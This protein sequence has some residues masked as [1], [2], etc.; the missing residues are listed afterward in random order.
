MEQLSI[1]ANTLATEGLNISHPQRTRCFINPSIVELH[2][3]FTT[4][5]SHALCHSHLCQQAAGS[6]D[7]FK[8]HITNCQW[9][10]MES[11]FIDWDVHLAVV[12]KLTFSKKRLIA[13][14]NFPWLPT[15]HQWRKVDPSHS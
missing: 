4:I 14:S 5:T 10:T 8:W 11:K 6:E 13:K 2:V 7:F 12:P 1:L 9:T 15:G 3:N